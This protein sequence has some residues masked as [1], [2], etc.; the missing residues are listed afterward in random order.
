MF[1][2][3]SKTFVLLTLKVPKIAESPF[4]EIPPDKFKLPPTIIPKG[5]SVK[6]LATLNCVPVTV[7]VKVGFAKGASSA[8][9]LSVSVLV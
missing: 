4:A 3:A 2:I 6:M 9:E 8:N 5:S 1:A 7:P